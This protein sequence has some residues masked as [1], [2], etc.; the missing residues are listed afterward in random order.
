MK[1]LI[2]NSIMSLFFLNFNLKMKLTTFLLIISIFKIEASNYAQNT[3]ITL[4]LNNVTIEKVLK[5][6]EMKTEFKFLF[7]RD[8][9]NVNKL[10]SVKAKNE[11]V[12]NIL[13]KIF[14]EMAVSFEL[15]N[16]QIIIKNI[17]KDKEENPI[18]LLID[19]QLEIKGTV[20]NSH[21]TPLPGVTVIIQG[22]KNGTTTDFD[23]KFSIKVGSG[24]K[25]IFSFTGMESKVVKITNQTTIDVVLEDS[26]EQLDELVIIGYGSVKKSDLTG[27]VSSVN[28]ADLNRNKSTEVLSALQGKVAGVNINSQSGEMGS[29]VNI[30]IRGTSSI[31]G[32]SNPLFVIDG[33]PFDVNPN[34][35]VSASAPSS[36]DSNPLTNINPAD[37]E[38]IEVLKDASATAIYGSRGANGVVLITTKS[39]RDGVTRIDYDYYTSYGTLSKKLDILSADKFIEFQRLINPNGNLVAVGPDENGEYL[40]INFDTIPK[41]DWQDEV[42]NLSVSQS[43]NITVSGGNELTTFSGSIGYLHG[44]GII[45]Q[46]TN[47]RYTIRL[48]VDNQTT[49]KLKIGFNLNNGYSVL[50][51]ATNSGANFYNKGIVQHIVYTKPIEVADPTDDFE[52]EFIGPDKLLDNASKTRILQNFRGNFNINYDLTEELSLSNILGGRLVNS[53]GKEFYNSNSPQG[54]DSGGLAYIKN[55][56]SKSINNTTQLTFN[57]RY[58]KNHILNV[59]GAFE[60]SSYDSE[61][62]SIEGQQFADEST[63]VDNISKAG[64]VSEYQS[65][66]YHTNRLSYIS[67]VNYNLFKR[68]LFTASFRA[69]GSDKFGGNNKYAYFPSAAFAWKVSEEPFMKNVDKISQLKFRLSYG[70]TGNERIPAYRYL[71]TQTPTYYSSN[72]NPIYGSSPDNKSNPDL[73]WEGTEQFNAG[74]DLGI[75]KNRITLSADVYKK[76]TTN[77]LLPAPIPSVSGFYSQWQNFGQ[78]NNKGIELAINSFNINNDNFK[79]ETNFNI[80][81]NKNKVISLGETSIIPVKVPGEISNLGAVIV[82]QPLGT[83]YGFA[84]DGIYQLTDF[85]W[86]NNSDPT[87]DPNGR[88]YV[89][90]PDVVSVAG[91]SVLPGSFKFKDLNND[92]VVNDKDLKVIS[93]SDPK[94]IASLTNT[95]RYKNF[96]LNIFFQGSYGNQVINQSKLM[97]ETN[98]HSNT[99][100]FSDF[101]ENR[102]TETNPSNRY[103]TLTS[104][105]TTARLPSSY[106]VEDASYIKLRSITL[107]FTMSPNLLNKLNLKKLRFY[108]TGN[109]LITLTKYTGYDPEVAWHD[110][111]LTGVDKLA[112]PRVQTIIIGT[113]I[114]F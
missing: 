53:K 92:G 23:G 81:S 34:E 21:G 6:I 102:W 11:K 79:W 99:N 58:N 31:Y 44:Q 26:L 64:V 113:N 104:N 111:L 33:V 109:N 89:I 112:F 83:G 103:G 75:L 35:V 8:D 22:T 61:S 24:N 97:L 18:N 16:K 93:R 71:G 30:T 28:S 69:D 50:E 25:L 12:K 110:P 66:H 82:G 98:F 9:I 70:V 91:A 27:S 106:Y 29:G 36:A 101:Y 57:K 43:H 10:V 95:F 62:N 38:S 108:I 14:L 4:D 51:G 32:S 68:Y 76:K 74:I 47:E 59:I 48:K 41:H 78:I 100:I 3:K 107:G 49:D 84:F 80:S 54:R 63:G 56:N 13:N 55:I 85:T 105:N 5:E 45:N 88:Q 40:P 37:I 60:V 2:K 39:G 65:D 42:F 46:N 73:K 86:Q 7:S 19:Q 15:L 17:P 72:G 67:R 96:D 90:K 52:D 114:T 87:I 77:M 1:N 20:T 94:F